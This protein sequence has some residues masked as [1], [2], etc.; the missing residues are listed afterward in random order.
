MRKW[1]IL[2]TVLAGPVLAQEY[3]RREVDPERLADDLFG[4]QNLDLNYE[5]LYENVLQLLAKPLN[6][7]QA[8]QE[9]LRF[10]NILSEEQL[11]NLLRYRMEYGDLVSIYEL[12][13]VPGF[14]LKTIYRIVPYLIVQDF[15]QQFNRS[16]LNRIRNNENNYLILRF[17]RTLEE[18]RGFTDRVRPEQRFLGDRNNYYIRFRTS[19]ANDFS[20]GFTL[21]KDAGETIT[22]N[23]QNRQYG[24]DYTSVHAQVMN[25]GRIKNLIIGD[26]QAQFAQGLMLGGAFGFGKGGETITTIRRS[27]MGFLPYTS[28]NETG[29][30]RGIATTVEVHKNVYLSGFYSN[31]WRDAT[32]VA[33][34]TE[35]AFAS[36]F[37]TT[38]LHRNAVELS[39][40]QTIREQQA[41]FVVQYQ[42]R[43]LDAGILMNDVSY[44]FTVRRNPQPYNQFALSGRELVNTGAYV[45]YNLKNFTLFSEFAKT[46]QRGFGLATGMI[47]SVTPQLDIALHFRNYQRDFLSLYSNALAESSIPINERGLYWGWRYRWNRQ[48][49][50][51]GYADLFRFPWL[52]Y[53]GYAPSDGHEFLL[54][55][56]YQPSRQVFLFAQFREESKIRNLSGVP[57]NVF[58]T[59]NGVKRNFWINADYSLTQKLRM[60]S[61]AQFST[62]NLNGMTTNG[63]VLLQDISADFGRM[64]V[65]ARYAL[66]GTDDFDNRQYVFER[67]VWLAFS[68]PAYSGAGIRSYAMVQYKAGR[69]VTFWLRYAYLRFTD[70]ETISSG[71]DTIDGNNRRD[72]N[73][74]MLVRI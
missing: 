34:T 71:P 27:N 18:R 69:A 19:R 7:N 61:R 25:K 37:Q 10:L 72:I 16:M 30:L 14:D 1:V 47:G 41:G 23:P 15:T 35:D 43:H 22:W 42:K 73:L 8:T 46:W 60:K 58:R 4:F 32:L 56:N 26:Y 28:I 55:F 2:L 20:F 24:F 68:M 17:A 6:V 65:T 54:R 44:Q 29:Y 5:D 3:P 51:A 62:Y 49:S 9:E 53:R 40:R 50:F 48:Y 45:N 11:Q 33:D 21:E 67:D 63:M 39:R 66:F 36:A 12:Q 31:A 59:D 38:G 52:R 57:D 70:R 74:Q 13:A 64:A